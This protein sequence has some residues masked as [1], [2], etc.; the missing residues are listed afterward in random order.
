MLDRMLKNHRSAKAVELGLT[1]MLVSLA[2]LTAFL[3]VSLT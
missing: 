1:F 2:G 3:S